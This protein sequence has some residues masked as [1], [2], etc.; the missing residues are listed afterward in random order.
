MALVSWCAFHRCD[1]APEFTPLVSAYA[2]NDVY[3]RLPVRSVAEWMREIE[4][5]VVESEDWQPELEEGVVLGTSLRRTDEEWLL[6]FPQQRK[7]DLSMRR[8]RFQD[9][10]SGNEHAQAVMDVL[11]GSWDYIG[12]CNVLWAVRLFGMDWFTT[13]PVE[14]WRVGPSGFA[15]AAKRLSDK[16]K[17]S[18][19]SDPNWRW[20][21]EANGLVGYRNQPYPGFDPVQATADLVTGSSP[22]HEW[23]AGQFVKRAE[24]V[25]TA[26]AERVK[27]VTFTEYVVSGDWSTAGASSMGRVRG[28]A[29]GKRFNLKARNNL[30]I[31][32][33]DLAAI[34]GL[35]LRA[36][37]REFWALVKSELGKLRIAVGGDLLTY[38]L[39]SY[40][41]H[42]SGGSYEKWPGCV[43]GEDIYELTDRLLETVRR[44]AAG[45]YALD[46]DW[47]KFD[48]QFPLDEVAA[49]TNQLY[50][51]AR[52][53]VPGWYTDEIDGILALIAAGVYRSTVHAPPPEQDIVFKQTTG[54]A[55]GERG[56]SH[57][58]DGCNTTVTD[59]AM[60]VLRVCQIE[61]PVAFKN[62]D[63][64]EILS[65]SWATCTLIKVG[66]DC[67]QAK[68]SP[69]KFS[70]RQ[71]VSEFLR[72]SADKE[73]VFG[74]PMRAVP[75]LVQRKPWAS[76]PWSEV[77]VMEALWDG[78]STIV[79]RGG[80]E[81]VAM[82]AWTQLAEGWASRARMPVA[83]L[84]TPRSLG[85]YGVGP[86]DGK[87]RVSI[88]VPRV[89]RPEMRIT[90]SSGFFERRWATSAAD[91]GVRL[92]PS[93]EYELGQRDFIKRM[94]ADSV[95][96]AA[97]E[98]RSEWKEKV[99]LWRGKAIRFV[100][101]PRVAIDPAPEQLMSRMRPVP[102]ALK[103]TME[104]EITYAPLWG[105]FARLQGSW[106]KGQ[107]LKPYG[108]VPSE[109]FSAHEPGFWGAVKTLEQ[110]G[111]HRSD[112][113]DWVFATT[114]MVLPIGVHPMVSGVVSQA[115]AACMQWVR[116]GAG[117]LK[118]MSSAF[119]EI[120]LSLGQR[121][122]WS[123]W[124]RT[125]MRW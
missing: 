41:I 47:E 70:V 1:P 55:S 23:F 24:K 120:A 22:S 50:S 121:L 119:S 66:Y 28:E 106:E 56:T 123:S 80:D 97:R 12:A 115:T 33:L 31:G 48:H 93:D 104:M 34:A 99:R 111:A 116:A 96:L 40:C 17:T 25:L 58:G 37:N 43:R 82:A 26:P 38:L 89:A 62:G 60:D 51:S 44:L 6:A 98:A 125:C 103:H 39:Q 90:N 108:F 78:L 2:L 92:T 95:P 15:R 101:G 84:S 88:P 81:V 109:W 46:F 79:R 59:L 65:D 42:L 57:A 29:A 124:Y 14:W 10:V 11:F 72:R 20:W 107:A 36:N 75:G 94:L 35:A 9:A 27:F 74:Y 5:P 73:G 54:L 122:S 19:V 113:L 76:S 32:V 7:V 30:A 105:K 4:P 77:N 71:E 53:N 21:A 100:R 8:T 102:G 16:L 118:H 114:A 68:S 67:L 86:W 117:D 3:S 69:G 13:W 49:V 91:L 85:G 110:R 52:P 18:R 61:V 45:I 83:A 63:D 64:V 112:A 87:L